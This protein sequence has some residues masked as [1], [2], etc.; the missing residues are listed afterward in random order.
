MRKYFQ[1]IDSI[2]LFC[3]FPRMKTG[4]QMPYEIQKTLL[5]AVTLVSCVA[6]H[7][8]RC[9]AAQLTPNT[10]HAFDTYIAAKEA[11]ADRD[12]AAG[13]G[14][15]YIDSLSP[16]QKASAY[17]RLKVGEILVQHGSECHTSARSRIPGGLI[18]DWT[19]IV[20]V[21]GISISQT[22]ATLQDYDHDVIFYPSEVVKSK[23]LS[24]SGDNFHI[25]LRL[26]QVHILTVVLDTEY[27]VHYAQLDP[28]RAYARSHST[29]IAEV[30]H[31]GTADEREEPVGHDHGYLWR[32][33][34]YWRFR[35]ADGGVYVQ[36]EAISLTRD[37]PTGL[38]WLIG[39]LLESIPESSLRSTLAETRTALLNQLNPTK[40][41]SP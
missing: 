36:V 9:S 16:S 30:D 40:E 15:L 23:L 21:P 2:A 4:K 11:S 10:A 37:V 17:A 33:D 8:R 28:A 20:F 29:R 22:L 18:H 26:K 38:G 24:R 31:A 1:S 25:Y 35:E 34:S 39:S 14:F 5:L 41:N 32:L 19:G 3:H 13:K 7:P 27:G 12:L 6:L